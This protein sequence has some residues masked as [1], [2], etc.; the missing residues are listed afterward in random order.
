[1]FQNKY[2]TKDHNATT[3]FGIYVCAKWGTG[4]AGEQGCLYE[5][6]EEWGF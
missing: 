5:I 6:N 2:Y 1:M 4:T 3:I